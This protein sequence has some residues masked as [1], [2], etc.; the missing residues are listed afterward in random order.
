M[1]F[2][3]AFAMATV[4]Q[5]VKAVNSF[6]PASQVPKDLFYLA[7]IPSGAMFCDDALKRRQTKA[8][9]KRFGKRFNRLI[10][11]VRVRKGLGWSADD[12]IVTPCYVPSP[13]EAR[14]ML[15]DFDREL[16]AYEIRF[17]R[18]VNVR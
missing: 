17:G 5:T 10:D 8:F 1:L 15:D 4:P 14:K 6:K 18:P 13:A 11:V 7:A 9:D 16:S 2:S 12:V 3:L